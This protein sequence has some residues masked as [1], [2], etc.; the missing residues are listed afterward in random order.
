MSDL[1]FKYGAMESG[2]SAELLQLAYNYERKGMKV[3]VLKPAID[4][5]GNNKI[6]TRMNE[7][8]ERKV[9]CL[10]TMEGSVEEIVANLYEYKPNIIIV[11]EAQ[12]LTKKQVDEL[13]MV[14]KIYNI[15]VICYGLRCDYKLEGFEGSTRL[16]QISDQLDELSSVCE[17]GSKST[18]NMK[19]KANKPVFEGE[20][21]EIDGANEDTEYKSVCGKCYV[22][23]RSL[24]K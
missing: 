4:T 22:R 23:Y 17:C 3:F 19:L 7:K 21:I 5:K 16:L 8:L 2:K 12:F 15:P 9:D 18:I 20:Q 14:S 6:V 1:I 11:D 10:L 13:Y 24:F